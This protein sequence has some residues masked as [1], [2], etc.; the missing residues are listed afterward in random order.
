MTPWPKTVSGRPTVGLDVTDGAW[1]DI[2]DSTGVGRD[3]SAEVGREAV[4]EL[5]S[6]P[7]LGWPDESAESA[8]SVVE[9]GSKS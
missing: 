8:A 2:S 7:F 5:P 3:S 6:T 4:F 1:L 9:G